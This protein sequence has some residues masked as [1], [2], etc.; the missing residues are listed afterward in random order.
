MATRTGRLFQDQNLNAH[1]NGIGTVS[2]KADF[3][4]QSKGRT[5]GRKPLGDLSNAGKPINQA[6]GKKALD[7]SLKAGKSSASQASNKQLKP[8]NLTVIMND[9]AVNAKAKNVESDRSAANKPSEKSHNGIRKALFDIS[10]SGKFHAPKVKNKNS[11]KMSSLTEE[12]PL[13][14]NAIAEEGFL[15]DHKKCIK[16]QFETVMDARHF[17]KIVGLENDP[18]DEMLI[19]FELPAVKLKSKSIDLELKEVVPEKLLEVQSL[20]SPCGS[21]AD[22]PKLPTYYNATLWEDNA[23]NF[24]LIESP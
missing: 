2:G 19:D 18:D 24:K 10:N 13:H 15:H 3:T 9:E 6:G 14:P 4:G 12:E 21:P 1:V 16:S 5:G 22:S 23:V 7:G 20:S 17:Y 11:L 8:E